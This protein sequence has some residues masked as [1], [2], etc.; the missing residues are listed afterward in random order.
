MI[1]TRNGLR[2]IFAATLILSPVRFLSA[3]DDSRS[4]VSEAAAPNSWT[5]TSGQGAPS[6]RFVHTA[7]WTGEKMIVWGGDAGMVSSEPTLGN[8]GVYDPVSNRW[9]SVATAGAPTAR[10]LATAVWTGSEMIVWGGLKDNAMSPPSTFNGGG[11]YDPQANSWKQLSTSGAPSARFG[12]TAV[13]TGSEMIVWGGVTPLINGGGMNSG[14]IY[15]PAMNTW[16]TVSTLNAPSPRG[17]HTAVWTGSRMIV[18][19]GDDGHSHDIG[20]GGIYDPETDTWIRTSTVGE[21]SGRDGHTAV[22]TGSRMIVWG[23]FA[24][25]DEVRTGGVFDPVAN[26]W[27]PM[28]LAGSPGAREL[29]VAVPFRGRMIVWGGWTGSDDVNSGGIYDPGTDTWTTTAIAGAP[30]GREQATAVFTGSTMIV[31]G[32][33]DGSRDVN[34]G[35]IYTPPAF[36][37]PSS[38]ECVTAIAAPEAALIRA[39]P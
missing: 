11:I 3:Q 36:P 7:V 4:V 20:G 28:T 35:G 16:R 23:G 39:R 29:H 25:T 24:N 27:K 9:S 37:C 34:S 21:P 30:S 38:R 5:A 2:L 1:K 33:F 18:W 19:G 31:W 13:W 12:H 26:S 8:G 15:D 32:G 17:F 6:G 22:W 14:G 10:E